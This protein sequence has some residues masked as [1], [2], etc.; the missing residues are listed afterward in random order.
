MRY[1]TRY[2][3]STQ[4]SVCES[5]HLPPISADIYSPWSYTSNA[6]TVFVTYSLIM[7]I[8]N[9]IHLANTITSW[10]YNLTPWPESASELYRLS[11]SR[12]SAKPVPTF[13]DRG[14][15]VV[16]VTD[17]YGRILGFLDRSRNFFFQIDPQLYSRGWVDPVSW[18]YCYYYSYLSPRWFHDTTFLGVG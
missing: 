13:V 18:V 8:N 16:S 2:L 9:V 6:L 15:H 4:R 5:E 3:S 14:C 7:H 11:E 1:W 10:A 17:S 12:L